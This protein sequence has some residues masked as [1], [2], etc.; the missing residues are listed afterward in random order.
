MGMRGF[1]DMKHNEFKDL[2]IQK[3]GDNRGYLTKASEYLQSNYGYFCNVTN[4]R[5]PVKVIHIDALKKLP[6]YSS[7]TT[8]KTAKRVIDIQRYFKVDNYNKCLAGIIEAGLQTFEE[9]RDAI[10]AQQSDDPL[11]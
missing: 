7:N 2:V 3:F 11:T 1:L 9:R 6:D 8:D 4:G 10:E 5:A